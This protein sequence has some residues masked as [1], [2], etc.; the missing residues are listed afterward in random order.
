VSE[1]IGTRLN[2]ELR[3]RDHTGKEVRLGD[4]FDGQTPV[5]LSLNY[6]D[7]ATLCTL[8]LNAYASAMSRMDWLPGREFKVVT[9]SIN[10]ENSPEIATLKRESY[11]EE[12]DREGAAWNFLLDDKNAVKELADSLGFEYAYDPRTGQYAH[13]AV[14]YAITPSGNISR[15]LYGISPSV[16]D[17]KFAL[18]ESSEGKLGTTIERF[19]LNCFHFDDL[20]GRYTPFAMGTMRWGG[21]VTAL[22]LG[23]W[24]R[25]L[26]SRDKRKRLGER[27][28]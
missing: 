18:M 22:G 27:F 21:A 13:A 16:R 4:F 14:T 9:V 17:L 6:Y 19:V 10:P 20:T 8:Q 12:L 24:L 25:A 2:L 1:R 23:L 11:L 3:F 28:A 26:W 15:Y 7:C 5:L